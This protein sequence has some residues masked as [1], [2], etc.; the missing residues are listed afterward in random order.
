MPKVKIRKPTPP[1]EILVEEYLKL[2]GL[3]QSAFARKIGWPQPKINE[4]VRGKRGITAETALVFADALGTT[5]EFWLNAQI[6]VDLAE[7]RLKHKPSDS[8]LADDLSVAREKHTPLALVPAVVTAAN[9]RRVRELR[10]IATAPEIYQFRIVICDVSPLIWRRV[11][12]RSDSTLD[13]L[14]DVIQAVFDWGNYHLHKFM[15]ASPFGRGLEIDESSEDKPLSV[16]RLQPGDSIMYE[17]DFGDSWMHEII[18]EKISKFSKT[19]RYPV[20]TAGKNAGPPEDC[21]GSEAYMNARNF[22]SRRKGKP[23]KAPRG[24]VSVFEK[25]FYRENYRGFDPDEFDKD[26]ANERLASLG[27]STK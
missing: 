24:R 10:E 8:K 9:L 14:S 2:M 26:E 13:Q 23:G 5:P 4:I 16:M 1:G 20:C 11:L 22:L 15:G 17:Y 12:V 19:R 21:G 7:A 18:L 25:E 6:A 3:S 27:E